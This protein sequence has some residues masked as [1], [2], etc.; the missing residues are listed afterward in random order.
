MLAV[1]VSFAR[2]VLLIVQPPTLPSVAVTDPLTVAF[3][4][5][6]APPFV[7]RKGAEAAA[8]LPTHSRY[9]ASAASSRA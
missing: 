7:T 9:V 6:S 3:V 8:E 1:P 4:A 5:V 2:Y